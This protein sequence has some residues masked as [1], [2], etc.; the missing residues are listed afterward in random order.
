MGS[1]G[2]K[3]MIVHFSASDPRFCQSTEPSRAV[4]TDP[5][6][7]TCPQCDFLAMRA[8]LPNDVRA[9]VDTL[10]RKGAI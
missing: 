1:G 3:G 2:D 5:R 8:T 7:V 4:T 10:V 9:F 6:V